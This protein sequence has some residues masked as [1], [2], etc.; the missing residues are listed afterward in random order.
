MDDQELR[1]SIAYLQAQQEK[2][3]LQLAKQEKSRRDFWDKLA[4]ISPVL[5]GIAIALSALLCTYQYNQQQIKLQEAQTV[6]K[7]I[8]HLMGNDTSK[9]MAILA[10]KTLVNTDLAAK[11]AAMFPSQGTLSALQTIAKTGDLQDRK[12]VS[13]ALD[14]TLN[15]LSGKNTAAAQSSDKGSDSQN[16]LGSSP[17][18]DS[19]QGQTVVPTESASSVPATNDDTTGDTTQSGSDHS[20]DGQS[21][22]L[23][24]DSHDS[25]NQPPKRDPDKSQADHPKSSVSRDDAMEL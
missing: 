15:E 8:P 16:A 6:E 22:T 3:L 14:K 5:S 25:D 13:Q 10:M 4:A 1:Q 21:T 2:I 19:A 23:P 11:Y 12:I 9:R 17:L 24:T 18:Q 7:F 20:H